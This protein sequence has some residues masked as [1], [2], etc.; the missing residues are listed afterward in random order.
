MTSWDVRPATRRIGRQWQT[1]RKNHPEAARVALEYWA[2]DPFA[3]HGLVVRPRADL[4]IRQ[5]GSGGARKSYE[6]RGFVVADTTAFFIVVADI[7]AVII[8]AL[9]KFLTDLDV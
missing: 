9:M 7:G 8:T 6:Q 5:W 3:P 4:A 2:A 1:L